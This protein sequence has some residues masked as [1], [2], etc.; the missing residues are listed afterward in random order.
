MWGN[1]L[2]ALG[3]AHGENSSRMERLA[4]CRVIDAQVT[5]DR[6]EPEFGRYLDTLDSALDLVEDRLDSL[7]ALGLQR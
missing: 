5:R 1:G 3:D 7:Q 4:Q 2:D 6:V